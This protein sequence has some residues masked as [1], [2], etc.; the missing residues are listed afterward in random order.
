MG[1][2][3]GMGN[4]PGLP[5]DSPPTA[6]KRRTASLDYGQ[7]LRVR[8]GPSLPAIGLQHPSSVMLPDG[9]WLPVDSPSSCLPASID[10]CSV[11]VPCSV[12]AC[13]PAG[14]QHSVLH[15]GPTS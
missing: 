7:A 13:T 11:I 10:A 2:N 9:N 14:L 12:Q 8:L 3:V 15:R 1:I 4:A 6:S 5:H